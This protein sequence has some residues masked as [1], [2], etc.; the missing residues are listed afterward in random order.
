MGKE[1]LD[2]VRE[3]L[4]QGIAEVRRLG[5][6][7]NSD[8]WESRT[9]ADAINSEAERIERMTRIKV[10]VTIQG[11]PLDPGPGTKTLLFRAF[12]EIMTNAIRH[13]SPTEI[14]IILSGGKKFSLTMIDNGKGFDLTNTKAN[15]GLTNIHKRCSMI[16]FD[17]R[18]TSS[19]GNGCK[20]ELQPSKN[21]T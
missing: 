8:L 7:L 20:W 16:D 13:G 14:K 1:V 15:A 17:A 12:Q 6:N 18:C 21:A 9:L 19:P 5:Q 11:E 3:A 4:E 2:S 10:A